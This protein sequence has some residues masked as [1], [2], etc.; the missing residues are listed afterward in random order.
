MSPHMKEFNYTTPPWPESRW[1]TI[2]TKPRAEFVVSNNLE[3]RGYPSLLPV[4]QRYTKRR[5]AK[6]APIRPLFPRYL[7]VNVVP[8]VSWYPILS[9]SGVTSLLSLGTS[10]TPSVLPDSVIAELIQRLSDGGGVITLRPKKIKAGTRCQVTAGPL[11]GHV[12]LFVDSDE[13]RTRLMLDIL[14]RSSLTV[15]PNGVV[16]PIGSQSADQPTS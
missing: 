1:L 3:E 5:D 10:S 14:G 7:F 4:C 15:V 8:G 12:G 11:A 9:L 16:H 13:D 2:Y 6:P